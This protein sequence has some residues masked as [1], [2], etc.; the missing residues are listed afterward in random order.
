MTSPRS[1]LGRP[2][3]VLSTFVFLGAA[4][5]LGFAA[6]AVGEKAIASKRASAN[7]D[8]LMYLPE[9]RFLRAFSLGHSNFLADCVWIKTI[10]YYGEHRMSDRNYPQAE[11]LF[12][13][14]YDLDS[15]FKGATR[16]GALVLSQ[17]ARNPQGALR[18]LQTAER[19]DSTAWE[20]PFDQ[21]FIQQTLVKDFVAAGASYKRAS[22]KPKAPDL[23]G[24]LA[25]LAFTRSGDREATREVWNSI[26][27]DPPNEMMR[28]VAERGLKNLAMEETEDALTTAV[29][30]FREARGRL[31]KDW[32]EVGEAGF[33]TAPPEEPWGGRYFFDAEAGSVRASTSIDREMTR[34][35]SVIEMIIARHRAETGAFPASLDELVERGLLDA[36]PARPMGISLEYDAATGTVTWDP[37]WPATDEGRSSRK[38][39]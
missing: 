19:G 38:T 12:Q 3:W 36:H 27:E 26:L 9:S 4:F 30:K 31:P 23:A 32:R 1:S 35:K 21:G 8:D 14:I 5:A 17:D 7:P 29:Q 11:R 25:G 18:L 39:S 28:R 34:Q 37:P 15:A 16:F 10:Q 33:L 24:R 2:P 13:S 22:E 20:Y 6:N